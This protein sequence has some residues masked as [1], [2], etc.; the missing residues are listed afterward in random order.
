MKDDDRTGYFPN[1]DGEKTGRFPGNGT[2]ETLNIRDDSERTPPTSEASEI[3]RMKA[4]VSDGLDSVDET[5]SKDFDTDDT[6]GNM[7]VVKGKVGEGAM[8]K[9]YRAKLGHPII[10][11]GKRVE[12]GLDEPSKI[13]YNGKPVLVETIDSDE[14]GPPVTRPW[15]R[16]VMSDEERVEVRAAVDLML[17]E[18]NEPL[19]MTTRR[20]KDTSMLD[21]GKYIRNRNDVLA[22]GLYPH[23]RWGEDSEVA[24]KVFFS[25][26]ASQD[27]SERFVQ[28][29]RMM[30]D[31]SHENIVRAIYYGCDVRKDEDGD[32]RESL[33]I[34][35]EL[36]RNASMFKVDDQKDPMDPKAVMKILRGAARGLEYL[37][38]EG[39]IHRDI[40]PSNIVVDWMTIDSE[41]PDVRLGDFGIAT[42][43]D[44][45]ERK[46]LVTMKEE[47]LL[48]TPAYMSPEAFKG[49]KKV[50]RSSDVWGLSAVGYKMLTGKRPYDGNWQDIRSRIMERESPRD[51]M[52][53]EGG[54]RAHHRLSDL[55]ERNFLFEPENRLSS[56]EFREDIEEL[57]N[58]NLIYRPS[59]AEESAAEAECSSL[60]REAR[61]R[62]NRLKW[63]RR[64][65][66]K[67]KDQTKELIGIYDRM[68]KLMPRTK[69]TVVRRLS[70]IEAAIGH[71][72][73]AGL[74]TKA[75]R[76]EKDKAWE[77][78]K[79]ELMNVDREIS[80][81][82]MSL[83]VKIGLGLGAASFATVLAGG[84]YLHEDMRHNRQM[85]RSA[86]TT[87]DMVHIENDLVYAERMLEA[88][89]GNEDIPRDI[90]FD[91]RLNY[92]RREIDD[93]KEARETASL[94]EEVEELMN[95]DNP[96]KA[97]EMFDEVSDKI[98]YL[99]RSESD[100]VR[101]AVS[102]L[103]DRKEKLKENFRGW[104]H[105]MELK[106]T[107]IMYRDLVASVSSMKR[108][109]S[110]RDFPE[111]SDIDSIMQN[112][113]NQQRKLDGFTTDSDKLGADGRRDWERDM[114]L[115]VELEG[116]V[117]G[118]YTEL[119]V[120]LYKKAKEDQ[121]AALALIGKFGE[122]FS[123]K[124][125]SEAQAKIAMVREA[126]DDI[127]S[128]RLPDELDMGE[129]DPDGSAGKAE[130]GKYGFARRL[131]E[132]TVSFVSGDSLEK[133]PKKAVEELQK[134]LAR[135]KEVEGKIA[136]ELAEGI[137]LK[138]L[139]RQPVIARAG[140]RLLEI[141]LKHYSLA[142]GMLPGL[143]KDYDGTVS[144]VQ[145]EFARIA[146][147]L[148]AIS[149]IGA[150][151]DVSAAS[152]P[153]LKKAFA[154]GQLGIVSGLYRS[155]MSEL[156]TIMENPAP[157]SRDKELEEA[158]KRAEDVKKKRA[159]IDSNWADLTGINVTHLDNGLAG[160]GKAREEYK[161]LVK[162]AGDPAPEKKA[163][164]IGAVERLMR[165]HYTRDEM[166]LVWRFHG[167][168]PGED[169]TEM[170]RD[171]E[172]F[173]KALEST[174]DASG[175]VRTLPDGR[176]VSLTDDD[177]SSVSSSAKKYLGGE[178]GLDSLSPVIEMAGKKGMQLGAVPEYLSK[179][180][181][182]SK[183]KAELQAKLAGEDTPE[184]AAERSGYRTRLAGIDS[185]LSRDERYLRELL[186]DLYRVAEELRK[187]PLGPPA[188]AVEGLRAA[189]ERLKKYK[190]G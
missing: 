31:L 72:N 141:A 73:A 156:E 10:L 150:K 34:V 111:M 159:G 101:N 78:R 89:E 152:R 22:R 146:G 103:T 51:I 128:S 130:L 186:P 178:L 124:L 151:T 142:E 74:K 18:W 95:S 114:K 110:S 115:Y 169:R 76:L 143:E 136:P 171:F 80:R 148:E 182:L 75:K 145:A 106:N 3:R 66:L 23:F 65:G 49:S 118:L 107:E 21:M 184:N 42:Y 134:R 81:L 158:G 170:L 82:P 71:C 98:A 61:N 137:D 11:L 132:D 52:Q 70:Y 12:E 153:R 165:F 188:G 163:E 138:A 185:E 176:A 157:D 64:F 79:M 24:V 13:V 30:A 57:Y 166:E 44:D 144:G 67:H 129:L 77:E 189:E 116:S 68:L 112:V 174:R 19:K 86:K 93:L 16:R 177:I 59:P 84:A 58:E 175:Y 140:D 183:E 45:D 17:R 102:A 55:I 179:I 126:L 36:V 155:L 91:R 113:R 180:S 123:E 162:A 25:E 27:L 28:E 5:I 63:R 190:A 15:A 121:E 48:G 1:D 54:K 94:L 125:E 181:A 109:I 53:T 173:R 135:I 26:T 96:K 41:E 29:G 7:A 92:I 9:L 88:L 149:T 168:V 147:Y 187:Y 69:D 90:E 87:L 97:I 62:E 39:V 35:E 40:K 8:G 20:S 99:E 131:Y 2:E 38:A 117:D 108:R 60:R 46:V 85:L 119:A 43:V 83:P 47:E 14:G 127:D 154:E 50:R 161:G 172:S 4:Y 164:R 33:Y 100:R 167:M 133:D 105:L 56:A 139:D 122:E 37:H 120:S 32:K 160:A 104:Y 6:I